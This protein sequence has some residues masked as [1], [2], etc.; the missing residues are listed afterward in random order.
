MVALCWTRNTR[1]SLVPLTLNIGIILTIQTSV[2]SV[3]VRACACVRACVH[4]NVCAHL[5]VCVCMCVCLLVYV[6]LSF[7]VSYVRICVCVCS[8]MRELAS[9][10]VHLYV[11][12]CKFIHKSLSRWPC[13]H[14]SATCQRIGWRSQT[15]DVSQSTGTS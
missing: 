10:C 8:C 3:C 4:L 2:K 1:P 9:V 13:L 11:C 7:C 12:V 5:C 6:Y 14:Q 15:E